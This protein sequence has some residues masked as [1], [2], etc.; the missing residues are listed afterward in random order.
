MSD[1]RFG[2][3]LWPQ[4]TG[5][6]PFLDAAQ[7]VDRLG[8]DTLWTWDHLYS[9]TGPADQPIFEA[10]TTLGAWAT[11]TRRARL[12]LM[13]GA[14]TFR[15]P[16]LV[17]KSA[18]TLDHASGGRAILGM[19]GGWFQLEHE[20]YGIPFGDSAGERLDWLDESVGIMRRLL[21]GETVTHDGPQYH[22][23]DLTLHPGPVQPRL[24]ILIGGLGE[25][26]TLRTVAKYADMWNAIRRPVD[27][28]RRKIEVLQAHGEAVGRDTETIERTLYLAVSI[29]DDPDE[30]RR[31]YA[32]AMAVNGADISQVERA[33]CGPPA[34]IAER[35]RP[36][37]DIGFRHLIVALPA[38]FDH[39]T[40]ER[41]TGEVKPL[42]D[43]E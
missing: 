15:N 41:L 43:E 27:E 1:L 38:P 20:A 18:I 22:A 6:Q 23:N 5:W 30:A 8:Y 42:L 17:A 19:G 11:A 39:E 34:M 35:M 12:G 7:L 3:A 13:T 29:R 26:K 10:W 33:W 14:N 2:I 31:V 24:P 37:L 32:S 9:D 36:Y 4:Q 16:G 21:D 28:L 25:Q 40:M